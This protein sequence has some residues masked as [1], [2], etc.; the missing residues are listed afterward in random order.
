MSPDTPLCFQQQKNK[1]SNHRLKRL[2]ILYFYRQAACFC[3]LWPFL[4]AFTKLPKATVTCTISPSLSVRLCVC[5]SV[6]VSVCPSVRTKQLG[7]HWMD[8]RGHWY[9]KIFA[10]ICRENSSP[11]KCNKNNGYIRRRSLKFII[12]FH[13]VLLR[14]R[15]ASDKFVGKIKTR[16]LWSITFFRKSCRLR[17]SVETYGRARHTTYD[18]TIMLMCVTCWIP[19]ATNTIS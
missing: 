19:K 2:Y 12:I 5:P 6:C 8:F 18:K 11:V 13:W 9:L 1:Q 3:P 7:F 4:G 15:N 16:M 17:D 10:K 14:M